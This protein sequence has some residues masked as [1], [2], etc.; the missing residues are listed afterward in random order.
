[1]TKIEHMCLSFIDRNPYFQIK[2]LPLLE[3]DPFDDTRFTIINFQEINPRNCIAYYDIHHITFVLQHSN[4]HIHSD[5]I[6]IEKINL[7]P[8]ACT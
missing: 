1:M 7:Q 2:G 3:D 4:R 6:R 5:T 8:V